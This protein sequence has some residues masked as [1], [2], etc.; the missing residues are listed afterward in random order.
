M[1]ISGGF[2]V[3]PREIG[4]VLAEHPAILE[5]AVFGVKDD[6]WGESIHGAMVCRSET[7]AEVLV[8]WLEKRVARF[9][10]PNFFN[11][12]EELPRNGSGKILK[13]IL[14]EQFS[15]HLD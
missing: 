11:R 3:Y 4:N 6:Q 13:R 10:I 14:V 1:I 9:K 5:C 12:I 8:E 7:S 15:G 2:N